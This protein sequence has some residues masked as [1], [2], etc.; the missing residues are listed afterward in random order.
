[1]CPSAANRPEVGIE[2]DPT[3]ARHV[4]LAPGVQIGEVVLGS[5]G[6]VERLL[7]GHELDQ[8]ARDEARRD[9]QL[10]QHV[11]EQPAES[12]H[13]PRPERERLFGRLHARLHADHVVD[14]LEHAAVDVDQ[15]VDRAGAKRSSVSMSAAKR[16]PCSPSPGTARAL[17]ASARA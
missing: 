15:E 16:A 9:A 14:R 3:G 4:R 12:R 11:H 13:E 8:V 2:P 5:G 17:A 10:T 7:I 6:P 1:M